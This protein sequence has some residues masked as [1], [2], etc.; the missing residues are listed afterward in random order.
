MITTDHN[1]PN[2]IEEDE[3]L[4][5][6]DEEIN[7]DILNKYLPKKKIEESA[8]WIRC[9]ING[10]SILFRIC[11]GAS[12]TFI[13]K[14]LAELLEYKLTSVDDEDIIVPTGIISA[15]KIVKA[16]LE[17]GSEVL[18]HS[19]LV[20][21]YKMPYQVFGMDIISKLGLILDF[22]EKKILGKKNGEISEFG[23]M[24]ELNEFINQMEE[25]ME[26][27]LKDFQEVISSKNPPGET[28]S[29]WAVRPYTVNLTNSFSKDH[30]SRI[31]K[32]VDNMLKKKIIE[33]SKE[34]NYILPLVAR[35]KNDG[36]L[37]IFVDLTNLNHH[38]WTQKYVQPN[39]QPEIEEIEYQKFS[40]SKYFS[41]IR[42]AECHQIPID[43][44]DRHLT[45]F[46]VGSYTLQFIKVPYGLD[47]YY[48]EFTWYLKTI[49][50]SVLRDFCVLNRSCLLIYSSE[51]NEHEQQFWK[52]VKLLNGGGLSV[53]YAKCELF[54]KEVYYEDYIVSDR[55]LKIC[56][57][58]IESMINLSNQSSVFDM[59]MLL[60]YIEK[61]VKFFEDVLVV[62]EQL[63]LR[64]KQN[65]ISTIFY[66]P[67]KTFLRLIM[68]PHSVQDILNFKTVTTT[69]RTDLTRIFIIRRQ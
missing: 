9:K 39:L 67:I 29:H 62:Q 14:K 2:T 28:L 49:L 63:Q 27:K 48:K 22:N 34:T 25:N 46:Q 45:T 18:E 68:R 21:D 37:R 40:G 10:N 64:V 19:L 60:N 30:E 57:K 20:V 6:T 16:K 53:D 43:V 1:K 47:I 69:I 7:K 32:I 42:I 59:Q 50:T 23:K 15:N 38:I 56:P 35:E 52:I 11:T 66:L 17:V 12:K 65:R 8:I 4:F 44:K 51:L 58:R 5:E 41:T 31:L 13:T 36:K 61:D 24:M 33:I 54:R 55:G 3:E 26:N